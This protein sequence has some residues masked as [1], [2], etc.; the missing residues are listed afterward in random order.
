VLQQGLADPLAVWDTS[1]V[2]N[3]TYFVKI[4]ASDSSSNPPGTALRGDLESLPFE[5][6][7]TPPAIVV[8]GVRTE[9][10]RTLIVFEVKDD[11]SPIQRVEFSDDGRRWRAVFPK[12]G[13][14]DSRDER[15]ELTIDGELPDRGLTLRASDSMNNVASTQVDAP[16][17][18]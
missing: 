18:R 3:G 2:P 6:D 13:M 16:R 1:T 7:N 10:A 5:I 12:D 14:A 8:Q 4:E 9:G 11:H 15:Y 17:K